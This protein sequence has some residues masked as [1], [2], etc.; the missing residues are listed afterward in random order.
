MNDE[1]RK[2]L[3]I[4]K[5]KKITKSAV[6]AIFSDEDIERIHESI[7]ASYEAI[8]EALEKRDNKA[9]IEHRNEFGELTMALKDF[10]ELTESGINLNNLEDIVKSIEKISFNPIINIPKQTLPTPVVKVSTTDI[11]DEYKASNS[12][13]KDEANAYHGFLA[14][15]GKWFILHQSGEKDVSYRYA[16]GTSGYL[17]A[18]N[19]RAGLTYSTYDKVVL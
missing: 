19:K 13:Y 6:A 17:A 14:R 5:K 12:D 1:Q 16:S 8:S 9:L 4:A 2:K 7:Q 18:W 11:Y 3:A 10:K 15:S